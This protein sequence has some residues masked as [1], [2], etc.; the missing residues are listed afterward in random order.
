MFTVIVNNGAISSAGEDAC[1][2]SDRGNCVGIA[3]G[4]GTWKKK[5]F[6][7]SFMSIGLMRHCKSLADTM[8]TD[9]YS[10]LKDA[11]DLLM[12]E[13]SV[14]GGS[15]TACCI[16]VNRLEDEENADDSKC[17]LIGLV[18][19]HTDSHDLCCC[20][21]YLQRLTHYMIE[22][23]RFW[24]SCFASRCGH[25]VQECIPMAFIQCALCIEYITKGV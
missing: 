1:F 11:F 12:K 6:D 20:C 16:T 25:S 8:K 4:V 9:G 23:G 15:T 7:S 17:I 24:I 2:I 14:A 5:G 19:I 10:I 3:D 21:C 13:G 18:S 22:S